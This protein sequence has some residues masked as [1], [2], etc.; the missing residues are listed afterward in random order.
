MLTGKHS[1][2]NGFRSNNDQFDGSQPTYPQ[3]LQ[4]AGYTTAVVGKWHLGSK[5]VG[6]DYWEILRGQGHYYSPDFITNR[7]TEITE[8][9][10]VTDDSGQ[11][12]E[13]ELENHY[14]GA[15]ST[16]KIADLAPGLS[17][18]QGQVETVRPDFQSQGASS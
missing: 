7:A 14:V 2:K 4:E 16:T 9:I 3:Y 5:P 15:Y 10:I 12:V 18:Q 17:G 13:V 11:V 1:H 8:E 6:F